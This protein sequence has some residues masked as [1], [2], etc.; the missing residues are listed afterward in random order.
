MAKGRKRVSMLN[1]AFQALNSIGRASNGSGSGNSGPKL[2][3][4]EKKFA[5][6]APKLQDLAFGRHKAAN[7]KIS[8]IQSRNKAGVINPVVMFLAEGMAP[9]AILMHARATIRAER[10]GLQNPAVR[11]LVCFGVVPGENGNEPVTPLNVSRED[12]C[13]VFG[14]EPP[15]EDEMQNFR[16][17]L[18]SE[19][20]GENAETPEDPPEMVTADKPP[21]RRR[22]G[23][24]EKPP[25]AA[26]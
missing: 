11:E 10:F 17:Q 21:V 18:P 4:E 25:V 3:K 19:N 9:A 2:S 20:E 7:G 6:I 14:W 26:E 24:Q 22:R 12:L 15:T 23:K 5:R 1:D 16:A 8:T 13:E